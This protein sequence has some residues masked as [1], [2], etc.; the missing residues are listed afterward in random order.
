M[1]CGCIPG[2]KCPAPPQPINGHMSCTTSHDDSRRNVTYT[3]R[4]QCNDGYAPF[5]APADVTGHVCSPLTDYNWSPPFAD[6]PGRYLCLSQFSAHLL[7]SIFYVT[8]HCPSVR[9]SVCL[10]QTNDS[11]R[12][13]TVL[14]LLMTDFDSYE[15]F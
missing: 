12:G 11:S 8:D 6:T 15:A 9:L 10:S 14:K 7:L 3:C 5:D 4:L 13:F 2:F 1:L